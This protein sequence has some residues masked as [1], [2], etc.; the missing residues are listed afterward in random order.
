MVGF[1]VGCSIVWLFNCF[2]VRSVGRSVGWSFSGTV[3]QLVMRAFGWLVVCL[4]VLSV[5]VWSFGQLVGRFVGV[6]VL[7]ESSV[8][9]GSFQY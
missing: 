7:T 8:G 6:C 3:G 9:V 4:V 2:V 1:W 5:V